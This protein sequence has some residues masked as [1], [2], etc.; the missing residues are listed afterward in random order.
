MNPM[1]LPDGAIY[2]I[3]RLF[4]FG[5]R[6]DAVGGC[7]RDHIMDRASGD[8]DITTSATPEKV[9]EIF[10]TSRIINTGIKHGTVTIVLDDGSYE[11]TT[12]R[13]DGEYLDNRHPT[14]VVFTEDVEHIF[15]KRKSASAEDK[16][17][18][19]N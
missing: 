4:S 17:T 13:L 2:I 18:I 15:G 9:S 5:E 14:E 16:L 10:S 1:H 19:D 3:D 7:V 6:A 8:Y 11:V 12:Y